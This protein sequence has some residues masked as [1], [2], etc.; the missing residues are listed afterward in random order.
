MS[1]H[2]VLKPAE[3]CKKLLYKHK[4]ISTESTGPTLP[5]V[6]CPRGRQNYFIKHWD[7]AVEIIPHRSNF[8]ITRLQLM[9][10]SAYINRHTHTQT[11][12]HTNTHTHKLNTLQI[13]KQT[14]FYLNNPLYFSKFRGALN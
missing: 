5:T 3:N 7:S 10:W 6:S 4:F 9:H 11:H 2:L 1:G 12:T 8:G 13:S 14:K